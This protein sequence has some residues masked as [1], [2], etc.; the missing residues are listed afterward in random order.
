MH[1]ITTVSIVHLINAE[2]QCKGWF[3][4]L[5]M[6]GKTDEK[7]HRSDQGIYRD[8]SVLRVRKMPLEVNPLYTQ[9]YSLLMV[10]VYHRLLTDPPE[11][12][13]SALIQ[14]YL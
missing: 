1:A 14:R 4:I 3:R 8:M 12:Q 5:N 13:I 11:S 10:W 2:L 6:V 9:F 7:F